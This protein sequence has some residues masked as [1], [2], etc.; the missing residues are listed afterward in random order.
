MLYIDKWLVENFKEKKNEKKF[1]KLGAIF[2]DG[3]LLPR[4]TMLFKK[5]NDFEVFLRGKGL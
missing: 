3:I 1:K 4:L 5:Y 2:C